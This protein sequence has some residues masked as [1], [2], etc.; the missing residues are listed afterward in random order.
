MVVVMQERA[1]DEQIQVHMRR[2][3]HSVYHAAGTVRRGAIDDE[4]S[5]LDHELPVTRVT[6]LRFADVSVPKLLT[7]NPISP[8]T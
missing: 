7:V 5:P 8:F 3:H 4:T 6:G 2:T 1:T